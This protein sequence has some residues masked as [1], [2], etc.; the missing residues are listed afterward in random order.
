MA[1]QTRDT[2]M[3]IVVNGQPIPS[4]CAAVIGKG[5]PLADGFVSASQSNGWKGDYF[6]VNEFDLKIGLTP[7]SQ[8]DAQ[9]MQDTQRAILEALKN[10]DGVA[11]LGRKSNEFARF[12]SR[13]G[14]ALRDRAYASDLEPVKITKTLDKSSLTLFGC[15]VNGTYIDQA[16]LIKRR[17]SGADS[18]RTYLRV[19][20]TGLLITDFDWDE[21]EAIK[22]SFSFVCRKAEIRYSVENDDGTMRAPLPVRTW[23]VLKLQQ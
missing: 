10:K 22:E 1:D 6:R 14:V 13:G 5:D 17:G 7:D 4:E 21:D 18:L 12:M 23:S 19:V 3:K 20:F 11:A 16:V 15:C 8:P 2:L 9:D